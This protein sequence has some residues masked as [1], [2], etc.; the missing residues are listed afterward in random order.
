MRSGI[1]RECHDCRQPE[2]STHEGKMSN[3]VEAAPT[4]VNL[5]NK[6]KDWEKKVVIDANPKTKN[7]SNTDDDAPKSPILQKKKMPGIGSKTTE[8]NAKAMN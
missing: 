7:F 8:M 6:W 4:I 3:T 2:I 5:K 1:E